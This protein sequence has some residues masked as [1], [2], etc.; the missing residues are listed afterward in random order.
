MHKGQVKQNLL[1][2]TAG[3][4][5]GNVQ[6]LGKGPGLLGKGTGEA[7][8]KG[9][10]A[11]EARKAFLG[12]TQ[13]NLH[14]SGTVPY[15]DFLEFHSLA[16]APREVALDEGG[17]RHCLVSQ[18]CERGADQLKKCIQQKL[19]ACLL[20]ARHYSGDISMNKNRPQ[21]EEISSLTE[22]IF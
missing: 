16:P 14:Q 21:K 2:A 6:P 1:W 5:A 17:N 19:T 20:C 12:K 4:Q 9:T 11:R 10:S 18:C 22:L 7:E 13:Q 8:G 15:P 3:Q